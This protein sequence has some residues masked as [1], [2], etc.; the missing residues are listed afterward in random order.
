MTIKEAMQFN[1]FIEEIFTS[2]GKKEANILTDKYPQMLKNAKELG[3]RGWVLFLLPKSIKEQLDSLSPDEFDRKMISV[4]S[5]GSMNK[6]IKYIMQSAI[7][8]YRKEVF[9][10]AFKSFQHNLYYPCYAAITSQIEGLMS[11]I[12]NEYI[13]G[14]GWYTKAKKMYADIGDMDYFDLLLY[15]S[16][17]SY[18]EEFTING[19]KFNKDEPT[20]LNRNWVLHGRTT[21]EIATIDCIKLIRAFYVYSY[22][23]SLIKEE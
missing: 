18:I 6:D 3:K 22:F 10:Q 16:L 2:T 4:Y 21:K 17:K 23:Y 12:G 13:E 19:Y 14:T 5:L 8:D 15:Q 11:D 9:D 20:Y 1:G 7:R